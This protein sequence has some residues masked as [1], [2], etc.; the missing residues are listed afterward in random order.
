MFALVNVVTSIQTLSW[1]NSSHVAI[2]CHGDKKETVTAAWRTQ[3]WLLLCLF[4]LIFCCLQ[5]GSN[6]P[7]SPHIST[8]S[9]YVWVIS[10]CRKCKKKSNIH[11]L[12]TCFL[13][14]QSSMTIR[15]TSS[16]STMTGLSCH[17]SS[18]LSAL[19][20]QMPGPPPRSSTIQRVA[21]EICGDV[22][23]RWNKKGV[24]CIPPG[25]SGKCR[26]QALV[27]INLLLAYLWAGYI[28]YSQWY[29]FLF[30]IPSI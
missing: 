11:S 19:D 12:L 26:S 2:L 4:I 13:R 18:D 22:A 1:L 6:F 28:I 3:Y 5:I 29:M 15:A 7:C 8:M 27:C 17:I 20:F 30:K 10:L 21:W 14:N 25:C 16:P 9:Y 23:T 24:F